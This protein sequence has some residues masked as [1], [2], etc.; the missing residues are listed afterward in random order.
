MLNILL[1]VM[2]MT[3]SPPSNSVP[4]FITPLDFGDGGPDTFGHKWITS[5]APGQ[6]IAYEWIDATLGTAT[7]LTG[8]NFNGGPYNIGFTFNYYGTDYTEF[9]VDCN[10]IM[11]FNFFS[12]NQSLE[13]ENIPDAADP[14][15]LLMIGW[16]D[17]RSIVASS[18]SDIYYRTVGTAPF[19]KLIVEWQEFEYTNDPGDTLTFQIILYETSNL[20]SYQYKDQEQNFY[21]ASIGIEN[22]NASDGLQFA[23]NDSPDGRRLNRRIEIIIELEQAVLGPATN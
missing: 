3:I 7:G 20:I 5:Y 18:V 6:T 22:F 14:D 16:D 4:N 13:D 8:D 17:L 21:D 10:G 23:S 11:G 19:R 2:L 9:Y 15:N 12:G 1:V